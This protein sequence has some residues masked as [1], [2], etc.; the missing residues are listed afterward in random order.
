MARKIRLPAAPWSPLESK[1]SP[2]NSGK[3]WAF[4]FSPMI[5][6]LR[7]KNTNAMK[8]PTKMVKKVSQSKL[9]PNTA[10]APPNPM[11]ADVLIK[12]AP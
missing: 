7:P 11:I 5:L 8:M 9:M 4:M 12:V 3:V 2:R 6:V 10:A 1:R